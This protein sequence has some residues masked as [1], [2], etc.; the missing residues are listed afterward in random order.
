[1]V[2]GATQNVRPGSTVI[3]GPATVA[4]V[5]TLLNLVLS[6]WAVEILFSAT[7]VRRSQAEEGAKSFEMQI[8]VF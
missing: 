4:D 1:M 8:S 5:A 6:S 2:P 3:V 7:S